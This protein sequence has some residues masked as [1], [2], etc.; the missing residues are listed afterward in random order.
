M[1]ARG[2]EKLYRRK[3]LGLGGSGGM[4]NFEANGRPYSS[5]V[6]KRKKGPVTPSELWNNT[7]DKRN[8]DT[9]T[10]I[11]CEEYTG[12]SSFLADSP[13]PPRACSHSTVSKRKIR[14]CLQTYLDDAFSVIAIWTE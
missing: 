1:Y 13:L 14:D 8:S 3:W 4:H 5:I 2:E 7:E 6:G 11:Q 12:H 9:S 10:P